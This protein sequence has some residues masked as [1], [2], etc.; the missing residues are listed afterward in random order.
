MGEKDVE[1]FSAITSTISANQSSKALNEELKN[2]FMTLKRK[3]MRN[4]LLEKG[5]PFALDC[6]FT[7]FFGLS[8][9]LG[10]FG[11]GMALFKALK[12]FETFMGDLSSGGVKIY[13]LESDEL[14]KHELEYVN[15]KRF[16][17]KT[18]QVAVE[19]RLATARKDPK[20]LKDVITDYFPTVLSLPTQTKQ[21]SSE[22]EKTLRELT[23]GYIVKGKESLGDILVNAA[24]THYSNFKKG[25]GYNSAPKPILYI[26]GPAGVGKTYISLS[27]ARGL[28]LSLHKVSLSGG[29]AK[30]FGDKNNPGQFLEAITRPGAALNDVVFF[31][32]A[33]H[34][35]NGGVVSKNL[36]G[37]DMINPTKT[38]LTQNS[39]QASWLE[40]FDPEAKEKFFPF[41]NAEEDIS[42]YL[43]VCAANDVPQN[44]ALRNRMT[45]IEVTGL[46]PEFKK[47]IVWDHILPK[48]M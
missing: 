34:S 30:V 20:N 44:A 45:I 28:Q 17:P 31:D 47:E 29:T 19:D 26:I 40:F 36:P 14:F 43:F 39:D 21:P 18:L 25:L 12:S 5:F 33:N 1:S 15:K 35:L 6:G 32:E 11:A 9:F 22:F 3:A 4:V 10:N 7:T 13:D 48:L 41:L 42:H 38:K 8:G 37:T 46:E 16:F 23:K 2:E 24:M 27:L